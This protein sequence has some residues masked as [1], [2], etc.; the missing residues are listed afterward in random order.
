MKSRPPL[1]DRNAI[2]SK[3]IYLYGAGGALIYGFWAFSMGFISLFIEEIGISLSF[4]LCHVFSK[5]KIAAASITL[6]ISTIIF[7]SIHFCWLFGWESGTQIFILALLPLVATSENLSDHLKRVLIPLLLLLNLILWFLLR[8]HTPLIALPAPMDSLMN[9]INQV[10]AIGVITLSFYVYGRTFLRSEKEM[11]QAHDIMEGMANTDAL[12]GIYNRRFI[13]E[14][15]IS[16]LME[17]SGL[18]CPVIIAL[19]DIDNFKSINDTYGHNNGDIILKS[20]V[21]RLSRNLRE[22][23]YIGRWGGEE[24]LIVLRKCCSEQKGIEI[25]GR[26]REIIADEPFEITEN[27][28]ITVTATMGVARGRGNIRSWEDI[29]AEADQCLYEGKRAGKNR[30]V[31][32]I[33]GGGETCWRKGC[34][35][36]L[37]LHALSSCPCGAN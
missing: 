17:S 27:R 24:F 19:L 35:F 34:F 1:D 32:R 12:T 37:P 22:D 11:V 2:F 10:V 6:G 18:S 13:E 7:T 26:L 8:N 9:L 29:I 33:G 16:C 23:D 30:V 15:F 5:K 36:P 3:S 28:T 31:S 20:L 14:H 21:D 25:I 4:I